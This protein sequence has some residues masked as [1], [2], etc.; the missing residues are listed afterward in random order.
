MIDPNAAAPD[1]VER[2]E[3]QVLAHQFREAFSSAESTSGAPF[4]AIEVEDLDG[5]GGANRTADLLLSSVDPEGHSDEGLPRL[6]EVPH[7]GTGF[8]ILKHSRSLIVGEQTV[9]QVNTMNDHTGGGKV[10]FFETKPT[11]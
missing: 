8:F 9:T 3:T 5:W 6:A 2:Q 11:E 4:F 10:E 1:E 7:K